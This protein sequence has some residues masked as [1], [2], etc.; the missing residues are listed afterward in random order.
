M[1]VQFPI[2]EGEILWEKRGHPWICPTVDIL[3]A[4]EQGQCHTMHMPVGE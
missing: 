2:R 3:K 4:A 1:E